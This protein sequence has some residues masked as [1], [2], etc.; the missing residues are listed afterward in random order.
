MRPCQWT[1]RCKT[2]WWKTHVADFQQHGNA[3]TAWKAA[4]DA[5]F[6]DAEWWKQD[7]YSRKFAATKK[8]SVDQFWK[9]PAAIEDFV[10]HGKAGKKWNAAH[11]AA[12]SV[13]KGD[14]VAASAAELAE[15]AKWFADNWWRAPQFAAD[16]EANGHN[17]KLWCSSQPGVEVGKDGA[18]K[19]NAL[20]LQ[21][22]ADFFRPAGANPTW[23][24]M[25]E[26]D[27][28]GPISGFADADELKRREAKLAMD[29]WKSPE[30]KEDFVKHGGKAGKMWNAATAEAAQLEKGNEDGY[31]AS[32][33]E[34][35]ERETWLK[36][37][38]TKPASDDGTEWFEQGSYRQE[39]AAAK[40]PTFWKNPEFVEDFLKNGKAGK[41]WNAANAAAGSVG[42]GDVEAAPA[43]ELEEREAWFKKNFWRAPQYKED[44]EKN[45]ETGTLWTAS[46]PD[47]KGESVTEA[48][49]KARMAFFKPCHSYELKQQPDEKANQLKHAGAVEADGEVVAT[50]APKAMRRKRCIRAR[51]AAGA[52]GAPGACVPRVHKRFCAGMAV[53]GEQTTSPGFR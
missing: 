26:A 40:D 34:L 29:W 49:R 15:R 43:A 11:A 17:G 8:H 25:L 6:A 53:S 39:W 14:E 12:A 45:G 9:E 22:R 16:F 20:E 38:A 2:N 21:K 52:P 51:A 4:R 13:N 35:A 10:K 33:A 42:K 30:V 50:G 48:E 47:G 31:Q 41:K 46:Q 27:A 18:I 5:P 24:A 36:A 44:F 3:G 37:N 28:N 7:E 32:P 23:Q 1:I 19:V